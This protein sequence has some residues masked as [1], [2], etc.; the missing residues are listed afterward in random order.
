MMR[1]IDFDNKVIYKL[2]QDILKKEK[3]INERANA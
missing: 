1:I 2:I 3:E